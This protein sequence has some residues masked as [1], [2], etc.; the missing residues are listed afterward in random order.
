M[1]RGFEESGA[2][3]AACRTAASA[4]VS[5]QAEAL[6]AFEARFSSQAAQEQVCAAPHPRP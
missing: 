2:A 1:G 6:A 3:A 5:Q 4:T